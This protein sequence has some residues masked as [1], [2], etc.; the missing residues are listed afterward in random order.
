MQRRVVA[1]ARAW[2]FDLAL[3]RRRITQHRREPVFSEAIRHAAGA[4][5]LD[6]QDRRRVV[7]D[8]KADAVQQ[9]LGLTDLAGR[10]DYNLAHHRIGDRVHDAAKIRRAVGVPAPRLGASFGA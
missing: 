4:G 6:H 2:V 9:L 3:E 8:M 10:H 7:G 5:W 1:V